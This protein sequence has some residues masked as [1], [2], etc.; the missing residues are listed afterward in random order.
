MTGKYD[1]QAPLLEIA[2]FDAESAIT[3]WKAGADRIELCH[4]REEGG[5]TPSLD[6]VE[7]VKR[8]VTIPVFV[9]IRPRGGNFVYSNGEFAQ[10][11]AHIDRFKSM[12]DGFVFGL[13]DP[14]N[15]V[16][17]RR[18]RELV[19][20]AKPLPCTF[21]RAF[22]EARDLAQALEAVV[23]TGCSAILSSGGKHSAHAGVTALAD[24]IQQAAA[25]IQIMPGGGVRAKNIRDLQEATGAQFFHSSG[26]PA[27]QAEVD[28]E[29]IA[30][31]KKILHGQSADGEAQKGLVGHQS[32][33]S[34]SSEDGTPADMCEMHMSA[35]SIGGASAARR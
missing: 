31:M 21:H 27:G 32:R 4:G 25:R 19:A 8:H 15:A 9:M 18:T 3:A 14:K 26:I 1:H 7:R 17:V 6:A 20:R 34:S 24:L 29:E 35:V 30:R 2:C 23:S 5:T 28:A 22:D 16:D 12:A 10:M 11:K 33:Q 13:L